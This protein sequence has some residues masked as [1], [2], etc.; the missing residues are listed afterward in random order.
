MRSLTNVFGQY[1]SVFGCQLYEAMQ[2]DTRYHCIR[3]RNLEVSPE[4]INHRHCR[5][6]TALHSSVFQHARETRPIRSNKDCSHT[7]DPPN[8][9]I[10]TGLTVFTLVCRPP[11]SSIVLHGPPRPNTLYCPVP[12][13]IAIPSVT[14][15]ELASPSPI[16]A[17]SPASLGLNVP[18]LHCL[19]PSPRALS[20]CS[21][22]TRYEPATCETFLALPASALD[23]QGQRIA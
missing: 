17:L 14:H 12:S 15:R 2:L 18:P 19:Y 4:Y 8:S 16:F 21:S 13:E 22:R 9:R 5:L 10:I 3:R 20:A 1:Q 23:H 7:V 6:K 11:H